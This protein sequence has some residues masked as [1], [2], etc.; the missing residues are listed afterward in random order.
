M[1]FSFGLPGDTTND[2]VMER[3]EEQIENL[4]AG[5]GKEEAISLKIELVNLTLALAPVEGS[6]GVS[7][8]GSRSE[9]NA[10]A[11]VYVSFTKV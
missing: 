6:F 11:S 3:V 9:Q 4:S 10:Q 2:T 8:S 1:S 5:P 7:I